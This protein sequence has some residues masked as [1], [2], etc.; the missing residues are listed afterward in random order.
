MMTSSVKN[1]LKTN[2]TIVKYSHGTLDVASRKE[3]WN[4]DYFKYVFFFSLFFFYLTI[5]LD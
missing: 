3:C 5:F 2:V 4:E 1:G